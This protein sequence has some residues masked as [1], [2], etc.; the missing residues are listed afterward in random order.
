M[1]AKIHDYGAGTWAFQCP[2]CRYEH[3]FRVSGDIS[4]PQ[5]KWNG[6]QEKPT[7]TPSLMVFGSDPSKR[8][9]SFVTNGKIQFLADCFHSLA[10]QTVELPDWNEKA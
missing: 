8:C 6:S 10:G 3:A 2:G 9:H 7:F 4:R 1:N 5:W